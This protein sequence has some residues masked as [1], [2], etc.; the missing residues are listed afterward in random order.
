[1]TIDKNLIRTYLDELQISTRIDEDGETFLLK[2]ICVYM[3]KVRQGR[4]L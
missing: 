2:C 1:M 4:S 3:Y